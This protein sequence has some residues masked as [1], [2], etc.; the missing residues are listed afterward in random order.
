MLVEVTGQ[1]LY[2]YIF[3]KDKENGDQWLCIT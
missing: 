2:S 3:L 1:G